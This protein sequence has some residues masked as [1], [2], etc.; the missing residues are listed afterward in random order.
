M[1]KFALLAAAALIASP[2]AFAADKD[3]CQ[4]N[5]QEIDDLMATNQATLGEPARSEAEELVGQ[6]RQAQQAGDTETCIAH[7]TKALQEL[8]GP[9][10]S[11]S[12][13]TAGSASGAGN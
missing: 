1:K 2:A 5:L 11:D 10:S 8:K 6:A 13:G 9:G 7:T 3:L 4:L 12:N